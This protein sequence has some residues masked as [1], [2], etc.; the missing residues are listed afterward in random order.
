MRRGC[1]TVFLMSI[2]VVLWWGEEDLE[3]A[4]GLLECQPEVR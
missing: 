3:E 1:G 4:M 2:L